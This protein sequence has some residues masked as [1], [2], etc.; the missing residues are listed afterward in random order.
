MGLLKDL[1]N[2]QRKDKMDLVISG[3][4]E[5]KTVYS[6]VEGKIINLSEVPDEVFA[7]KTLGDGIAVYPYSGK[8][9]AP[10]NGKVSVLFSTKHAIGLISDN[11]IEILLH[12]GIDTVRMNGEG[13]RAYVENG[14]EIKA[15]QLLLDFDIA[16]IEKMGLNPVVMIVITNQNETGSLVF[17]QNNTVKCMQKIISIGS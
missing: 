8:V 15:G 1:Y 10:F 17:E 6:P 3:E 11:G 14:A 7:S 12:I 4:Y 2:K 9:Y 16:K 5:E 13:F